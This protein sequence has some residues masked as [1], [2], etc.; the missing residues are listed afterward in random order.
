M[1]KKIEG[2]MTHEGF[3]KLQNNSA[4]LYLARYGKD[5][6]QIAILTAERKSICGDDKNYVY[7]DVAQ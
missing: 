6:E 4:D 1:L 5:S 2:L 3:E 7:E